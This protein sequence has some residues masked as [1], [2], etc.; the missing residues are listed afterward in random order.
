[1]GR[2]THLINEIKKM[3]VKYMAITESKNKGQQREILEDV[4]ILLQSGVPK[5]L[6]AKAGVSCLIQ[7]GIL[8]SIIAR[9]FIN[10]RLMTVNIR[11]GH[12]IISLIIAYEL[13]EDENVE[14]GEK[15]Y[16]QLQH[17]R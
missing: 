3:E 15:F 5:T 2:G 6:T 17:P 13:N 16:V 12:D 9:K 1:M 14:H 11:H 10:E 8:Y 7:N 4:L